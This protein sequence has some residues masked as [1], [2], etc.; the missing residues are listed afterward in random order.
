MKTRDTKRYKNLRHQQ[1]KPR[2]LHRPN[3]QHQTTLTPHELKR[4]AEDSVF[5]YYLPSGSGLPT[6]QDH[7]HQYHIDMKYL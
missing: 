4:T 2:N 1:K 7:H 6:C 5:V 3:L